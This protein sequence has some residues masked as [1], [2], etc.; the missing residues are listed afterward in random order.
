[1]KTNI[2]GMRKFYISIFLILIAQSTVFSEHSANRELNAV[3]EW[4]TTSV[5]FG[6][7]PLNK[8]ITAEFIFKNPGMIPLIITDVKSSC[9]CTVA[10]YPKQPIPAGGQGKITATYDAKL[11]GYFNKTI[12]VYSNTEEGMTELYIKGEVVK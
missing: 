7:V 1:M 12:T 6:K 4:Q 3:I 9:G 8:A 11:S 5:D 10:D 2:K